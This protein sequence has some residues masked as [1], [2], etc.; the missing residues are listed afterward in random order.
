MYIFL[1]LLHFFRKRKQ[2]LGT[3]HSGVRG[4]GSLGQ[5]QGGHG[6]EK[7]LSPARW[8]RAPAGEELA[9]Q[10]PPSPLFSSRWLVFDGRLDSLSQQGAFAAEVCE[11]LWPGVVCTPR[12]S[13]APGPGTLVAS[14]QHLWAFPAVT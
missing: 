1:F 3:G 4:E 9:K 6:W 5:F 14:T 7:P 2:N 12:C 13:C 8:R 10:D 11:G